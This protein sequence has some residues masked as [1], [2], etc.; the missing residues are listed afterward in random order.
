MTTQDVTLAT[1]PA[2][3]NTDS[4]NV[5]TQ[6][7]TANLATGTPS[8]GARPQYSPSTSSVIWTSSWI[9][10]ITNYFVTQT[11]TISSGKVYTL[12]NSIYTVFRYVTT[13]VDTRGYPTID[14]I[15]FT[16]DGTNVPTNLLVQ[17]GI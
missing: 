12:T 10:F 14:G 13:S 6:I 4:N 1:I 9:S 2:A 7:K 17:R 15:Y 5:V 16:F 8:L 11:T 3:F